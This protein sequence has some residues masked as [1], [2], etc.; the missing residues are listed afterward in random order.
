MFSPDCICRDE[1]MPWIERNRDRGAEVDV[2]KTQHQVTGIEDSSFDVID[3]L[4]T[5]SATDKF[6]IACFN[7]KLSTGKRDQA[8]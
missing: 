7:K 3:A 2:A 1:S 5:V 8:N 6:K 4:Q